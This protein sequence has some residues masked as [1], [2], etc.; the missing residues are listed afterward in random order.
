MGAHP[1]WGVSDLHLPMQKAPE[2]K[3]SL[4]DPGCSNAFRRATLAILKGGIY[5]CPGSHRPRNLNHKCDFGPDYYCTSWGCETTGDT[6]WK[7]SSSWDLITVK[8][9]II[10]NSGSQCYAT[11]TLEGW[12]NPLIISFTNAGKKIINWENFR[13]TEWGL[14]LYKDNRDYGLLFKVKLTKTVPQAPVTSV[15]PNRILYNPACHQPKYLYLHPHPHFQL[16]FLPGLPRLFNPL[17]P[18]DPPPA[19]FILAMVNAS[20]SAL[21]AVNISRFEECWVFH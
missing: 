3:S 2:K 11:G 19:D 21:H 10:A 20:L 1:Y 13:G 12:C 16:L 9:E 7:P 17:C 8:R 15:G 14:R 6:Y 4:I 5:V 18:R